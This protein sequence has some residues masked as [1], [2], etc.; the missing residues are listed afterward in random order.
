MK[1]VLILILVVF[2]RITAGAQTSLDYDGVDDY[3]ATGFSGILGNNSRTVEF[4]FKTADT[5]PSGFIEWGTQ[6]IAGRYT[7]A[8]N[9]NKLRVEVVGSYKQGIT[10]IND[11]VWH[12]AAFVYNGTTLTIYLDGVIE[13]SG[14]FNATLNTTN[15][16][17][18]MIGRSILYS[19]RPLNGQMDEVRIWNTARTLAE[20]R[21]NMF[22]ELTGSE[23]NLVLYF[24]MESTTTGTNGVIDLTGT[25][26]G[27]MTN[28]DVADIVTSYAATRT[29]NTQTNIRGI[30]EETGTANSLES[31]GFWMDVNSTLTET[32]YA[33]F[34]HD[35]AGSS[36]VSTDIPLPIVQRYEQIWNVIGKGSVTSNITFDLSTIRGVSITAGTVSG[37][38]L[39]YRIGTSGTFTDLGPATSTANV[40]QVTFSAV[41]LTDGYY[42]IGTLNG[43]TS[44]LPIELINFTAIPVNNNYIKIDWQTASEINNDYFIIERSKDL[45]NWEE[46][47]KIDGAG[48]SSSPLSYSN[49]DRNPFLGISYYRLKQ[50]DFNGQFEYSQ[51]RSVNI[52]SSVNLQVFPNPTVSQITIVGNSSELEKVAIY[53]TVGQNVTILTQ[54]IENNGTRVVIDITQLSS[55][56]Y[57]IKTETTANKLYKE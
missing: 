42:T 20:I 7:I 49:T 55:G 51:V 18:V 5:G 13:I 45:L 38:R 29:T 11:D 34:G 54:Q 10:A 47:A 30:W 14:V 35:N 41:V 28:M 16:A 26:N 44:P 31:D 36:I 33:T 22:H 23:A 19:H 8:L 48:N 37:Y 12:H 46:I 43:S 50:T 52:T 4:W 3:I 39:L 15:T 24:S 32:N 53:N 25:N 56:I 21:D 6:A 27:T 17:D 2:I 1:T 9:S 40:D 57:Y